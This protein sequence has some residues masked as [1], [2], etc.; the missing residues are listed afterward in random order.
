MNAQQAGA[1]LAGSVDAT[2]NVIAAASFFEDDDCATD[3]AAIVKMAQNLF[4]PVIVILIATYKEKLLAWYDSRHNNGEDTE[5]QEDPKKEENKSEQDGL[6]KRMWNAFPKFIFGYLLLSI[7][8]SAVRGYVTKDD[9]EFNRFMTLMR[10]TGNWWF[11]L[12]FVGVGLATNIAELCKKTALGKVLLFVTFAEILD[13][14]TTFGV[15]AL[16]Y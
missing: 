3:V 11:A 6:I 12:G 1:A 10:Q 9:D 5:A 8:M 2:G 15:A 13:F 4:L 16:V 14:V 7:A